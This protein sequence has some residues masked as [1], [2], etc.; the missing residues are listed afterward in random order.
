MGGGDSRKI[1]LNITK[2]Y[3]CGKREKTGMDVWE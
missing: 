3:L 1:L 2:N